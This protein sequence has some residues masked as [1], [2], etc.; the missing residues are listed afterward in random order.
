MG[1]YDCIPA[2][3]LIGGRVDIISSGDRETGTGLVVDGSAAAAA[4]AV[5]AAAAT[6]TTAAADKDKIDIQIQAPEADATVPYKASVLPTTSS[7]VSSHTAAAPSTG[8][9]AA[10]VAAAA[11]QNR[12]PIPLI[13]TNLDYDTEG[14]LS[15]F[16]SSIPS[17][18]QISTHKLIAWGGCDP[19]VATQITSL[20][21]G[22]PDFRVYRSRDKQGCAVGWNIILKYMAMH[23][24][25]E[26]PW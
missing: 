18:P 10:A 11:V 24:R 23:D 22:R 8:A 19:M 6:T 4:A 15:R 16:A 20:L 14:Y 12:R 5:A 3:R 13:G 2:D 7:F 1:A 26:I 25:E 9:A 17:S 21:E